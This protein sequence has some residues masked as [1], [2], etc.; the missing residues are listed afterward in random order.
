MKRESREPIVETPVGWLIPNLPAHAGEVL[1][2][3]WPPGRG[4][5][6]PFIPASSPFI[7]HRVR[8]QVAA[9]SETLSASNTCRRER[10]PVRAF[11]GRSLWL[12]RE[13]EKA[14]RPDPPQ[15]CLVR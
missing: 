5:Q 9:S 1:V 8:C 3:H 6:I 11:L 12:F 2:S 13:C 7:N 15:D 14:R 10:P 4:D